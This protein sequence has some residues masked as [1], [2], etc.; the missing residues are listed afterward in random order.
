MVTARLATAV[1][2]LCALLP[3][4]IANPAPIPVAEPEAFPEPQPNP[5][6][7]CGQFLANLKISCCRDAGC[8]GYLHCNPTCWC[9]NGKL[10]GAC[11][12]RY[13]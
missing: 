5:C 2:A 9:E 10:K 3:I 8:N 7:T 6:P 4:V 13:G 11:N 12:C 1:I